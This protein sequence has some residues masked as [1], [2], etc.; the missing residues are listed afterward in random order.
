M[1]SCSILADAQEGDGVLE[2]FVALGWKMNRSQG[3]GVSNLSC[4]I[5]FLF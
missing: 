2:Y 4:N 3:E 5:N 1:D